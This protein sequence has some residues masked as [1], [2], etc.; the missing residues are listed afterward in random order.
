MKIGAFNWGSV[1][2][3]A[4]TSGKFFLVPPEHQVCRA[5]HAFPQA[6]SYGGS[7]LATPPSRQNNADFV[8]NSI[9]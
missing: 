2:L 1:G 7:S 9:S 6:L 5:G 4:D 3:V 8:A